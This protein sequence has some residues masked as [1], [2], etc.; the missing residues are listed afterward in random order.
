MEIEYHLLQYSQGLFHRFKVIPCRWIWSCRMLNGTIFS[1]P[2]QYELSLLDVG[3]PGE[4]CEG[5][6]DPPQPVLGLLRAD[7]AL[8][9]PPRRH[10]Y[11]YWEDLKHA[12]R[13]D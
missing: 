12:E 10:N 4:K 8:V 1:Q 6:V 13:I 11:I 9:T 2:R 3:L 5:L 7:H